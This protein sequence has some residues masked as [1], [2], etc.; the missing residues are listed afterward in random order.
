MKDDK[1]GCSVIR[2]LSYPIGRSLKFF[3]DNNTNHGQGPK[4][5]LKRATISGGPT[6]F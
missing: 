2:K 5:V 6:R 3:S 1:G 4:L